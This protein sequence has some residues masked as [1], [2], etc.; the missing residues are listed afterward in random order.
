[1]FPISIA[2]S[3]AVAGVCVARRRGRGDDKRYARVPR[4]EH[5]NPFGAQELVG[6]MDDDPEDGKEAW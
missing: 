1:M 5:A 4:E 3:G 6:M 2:V